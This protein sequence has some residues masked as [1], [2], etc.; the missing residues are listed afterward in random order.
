MVDFSLLSFN[1]NLLLPCNFSG[2]FIFNFYFVSFIQVNIFRFNISLSFPYLFLL[3]GFPNLPLLFPNHMN[4]TKEYLMN[5]E[6]I[7][8]NLTYLVNILEQGGITNFK[9]FRKLFSRYQSK[10]LIV[11]IY[12]MVYTWEFEHCKQIYQT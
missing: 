5:N 11:V 7:M 6:Y 10:R 1:F 4:T 12:R 9:Y 3:K 2:V 8:S